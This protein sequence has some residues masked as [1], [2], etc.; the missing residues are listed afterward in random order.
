MAF[1]CSKCNF[2]ILKIAHTR[3]TAVLYNVLFAF[4]FSNITS[5]CLCCEFC[6]ENEATTT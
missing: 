3:S 2:S 1:C 4:P 6:H 5:T